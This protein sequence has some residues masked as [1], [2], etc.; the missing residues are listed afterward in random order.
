[1][2][3]PGVTDIREVMRQVIRQ[4]VAGLRGG[5]LV[6]RL[7]RVL[8]STG[9]AGSVTR[10][11][12]RYTVSVQPL[13]PTGEDDADWPA[14]SD[15]PL[16]CVWSGADQGVFARPTTGAIVVLGF[17]YGQPTY[18]VIRSVTALGQ[19]TPTAALGEFIIRH[20]SGAEIR[21]TAEGD[22]H[23]GADGQKL[24][25]ESWVTER[26][27]THDHPHA[28]GP[29]QVPTPAIAPSPSWFTQTVKVP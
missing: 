1:M 18:P 23:L 25:T 15:V 8:A 7:A 26:F 12:P 9:D 27:D 5:F 4:E 3:T 10:H 19:S 29:T 20:Q 17:L 21:I 14:I 24:V 22:I 6:D 28:N 11:E 16:P 2:D 13:T